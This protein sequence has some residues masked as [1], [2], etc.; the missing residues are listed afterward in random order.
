MSDR[1]V[2][3]DGLAAAIVSTV[4]E[5]TEEV[6]DGIE[7]IVKQT[8]DET[9]KILRS[10]SPKET[11]SYAKGWGVKKARTARL[12]GAVSFVVYNRT[13]YQLTH[14]LEFGHAN[15]DGSFTAARPHIQS[16]YERQRLVFERRMAS[17]VGGR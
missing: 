17:L 16:A 5:Y 9:V 2:T 12:S 7:P 15:R 4:R 6:E 3:I 14:L 11:G 1:M 8:V 10:D 13:D